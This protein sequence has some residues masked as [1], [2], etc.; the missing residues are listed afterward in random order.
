[1]RPNTRVRTAHVRVDGAN[2]N[3]EP[4]SS[5]VTAE[6]LNDQLHGLSLT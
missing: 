1:M 4:V 5:F 2:G 3:L 6:T